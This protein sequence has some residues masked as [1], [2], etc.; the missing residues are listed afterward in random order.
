[1]RSVYL[2]LLLTLIFSCKESKE[3]K[4]IRLVTEWQGRE[5][6]FPKLV[7]FTSVA[8]DS[9]DYEMPHS[10]YKILV[11]VDSIGCISCKL[12]L[13]R[14]KNFIHYLDSTCKDSVP[15]LFFFHPQ[16]KKDIDYILKYDKFTYPVCIDTSDSLNILNKFPSIMTFQTFL[17]DEHNNVKLIGNP[18]NNDN[19][20]DLYLN[21]LTGKSFTNKTQKQ[22]SVEV[23]HRIIDVGKFDSNEM[24]EVVFNFK[25]VGISPFVI[26]DISTSCGCTTAEYDKQPVPPGKSLQVKVIIK[27][28][29]I[30]FFEETITIK[31]NASS[32]PVKLSIKGQ[33]L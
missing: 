5:I 16:T 23:D 15:V 8:S 1:M 6:I 14:W 4:L 25:N 27:P 22:T 7:T 20:K 10:K 31:C 29:D 13:P 17:L 26:V 30:G 24:K 11:Y 28:K 12:Q 21:L 18:I 2:L 32:S 9:I 19:V 3:D 33:A